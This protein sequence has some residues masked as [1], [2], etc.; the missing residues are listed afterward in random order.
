MRIMSNKEGG[1]GAHPRDGAS[2]RRRLDGGRCGGPG[3]VDEVRL[4]VRCE[5][6]R[7]LGMLLGV[8]VKVEGV[9]KKLSTATRCQWQT[10][11]W[12]GRGTTIENEGK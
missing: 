9:L 2:M 12:I 8:K 5:L 4:S 7:A 11:A 1:S 10:T 6:H 3:G